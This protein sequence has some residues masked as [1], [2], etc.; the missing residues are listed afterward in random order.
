MNRETIT[1]R[2][3]G[4]TSWECGQEVEAWPHGTTPGVLTLAAHDGCGRRYMSWTE[5]WKQAEA[6]G[7]LTDASD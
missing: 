4:G 1:V 7:R 3:P 6:R 2:C 5:A